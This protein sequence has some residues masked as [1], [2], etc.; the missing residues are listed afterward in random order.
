MKIKNDY[1]FP[2][3]YRAIADEY[4]SYKHSLGFKF[5]YDDQKKCDSLLDYLY[6]N[7]P[8]HNV[9]NL[10][11]ELADGYM[12]HFNSSR[13]RTIHAS[14]SCIRQ[15]GLFLKRKGYDPYIYPST[16]IQCPKDFTPY[17]FSKDEIYR[18]FECA[19]QIG[20][21]KNK[22]MNTPHVYPAILRLLYSCGPRIGETVRLR[23]EDVDLNEGILTFHNGK[24]NVSRMIPM[25][26]SLTAYLRKYDSRVDRTGN[27]YFFPALKGE[28]YSPTTILNTFKKL[29]IQAGIPMLPTGKYPRIHDLRHTFAVHSLEHSID[30]GQDPYC[31]LPSLSTYMGHKGIE[32]TEYYLRLTKHYFINVLHYTQSQA[33]AIFP[34]VLS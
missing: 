27:G 10:T 5:G 6:K 25:S 17:I 18:I 19:D 28:C 2:E 22:F 26:G 11:K 29:M 24:N 32:S 1:V 21:N 33:D 7:S 9:L 13:P 20:P 23:T 3:Q 15:Y 8:G 14:Q 16:L 34:E 30:S 31:S 12:G 4:I